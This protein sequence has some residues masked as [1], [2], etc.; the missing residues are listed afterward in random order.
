V[1]TYFWAAANAG[2]FGA[3]IGGTVGYFAT[4]GELPDFPRGI[5]K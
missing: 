2:V 4:P 3:V 5:K 1:M